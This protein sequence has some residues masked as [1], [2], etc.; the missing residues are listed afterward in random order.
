MSR[1]KGSRNLSE[2]PQFIARSG[3]GKEPKKDPL[4]RRGMPAARQP[5]PHHSISKATRLALKIPVPLVFYESLKVHQTLQKPEC[6]SK[7]KILIS[8]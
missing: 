1:N 2:G 8:S 5:S 4:T 3:N 6:S 7:R